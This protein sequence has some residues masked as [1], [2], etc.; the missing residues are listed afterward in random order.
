MLVNLALIGQASNKR[1]TGRLWS[2]TPRDSDASVFPRLV[3]T[4][5]REAE[6]DLLLQVVG[7]RE[8]QPRPAVQQDIDCSSNR[9]MLD[10][11]LTQNWTLQ[12][13]N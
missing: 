3:R 9:A 10:G 2:I 4:P 12:A 13:R 5:C 1:S 11:K 8:V 6:E 7:S